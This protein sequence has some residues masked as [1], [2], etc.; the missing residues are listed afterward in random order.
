M[1][2][3]FQAID[4][5]LS[6]TY[7]Q[8]QYIITDDHSEDFRF[9]DITSYIQKNNQGNIVDFKIVQTNENSGISNN[10]NYGL[11]FAEG[12]Y[13][14]NLAADD[15][16][17]DVD[18]LDEWV[19]KFESTNAQIITA[20]RAVYDADLMTKLYEA[21]T[22]EEKAII[23]SSTPSELFEAMAGYNIV[24][25]CCT[26]RTKSN[27]DLLGGYDKQYRNIEDYPANMKALRN[28][29]NILFWDRTVIKYRTGGISSSGGLCTQYLQ[30]SDSIF[31]NEILPYTANKANAKRRYK[32]WK[33]NAIYL[34]DKIK[35][36]NKLHANKSLPAKLFIYVVLAFRHPII[37]VNKAINK[38][39]KR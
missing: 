30:E 17:Y 37:T 10:L 32:T 33:Y 3:I 9:D 35:L 27:Y 24:F 16:F 34:A 19:Q 23:K 4:S 29:I 31:Q 20:E 25:G 15:A 7:P 28:G 22:D 5:V 13:L 14:F 26:A 12:K 38:L 39:F 8:I 1:A 36:A 11:S 18:V 2:T 6:Q 21:P